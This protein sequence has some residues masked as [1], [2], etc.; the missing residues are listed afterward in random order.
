MTK[1]NE[2]TRFKPKPPGEK[3]VR[4]QVHIRQDQAQ[5]LALEEN[6]SAAIRAA[7]DQYFTV[8]APPTDDTDHA[9]ALDAMAQEPSEIDYHRV[10]SAN[11]I[12]LAS[13]KVAEQPV[14]P[15]IVEIDGELWLNLGSGLLAE[16]AATILVAQFPADARAQQNGM[17]EWLIWHRNASQD[18]YNAFRC[19]IMFRF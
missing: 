2:A 9:A 18:A 10:E 11:E 7:L 6:Q 13:R 8:H 14:S 17:E 4:T 19:I 15:E 5:R 3:M 16:A 1:S 12:S